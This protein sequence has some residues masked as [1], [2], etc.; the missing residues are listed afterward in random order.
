MVLNTNLVSSFRKLVLNIYEF[1]NEFGCQ[2]LV[3]Q[4]ATGFPHSI[5]SL[6][7]LFMNAGKY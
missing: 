2:H 7:K 3:L 6:L 1:I 4:L 5:V